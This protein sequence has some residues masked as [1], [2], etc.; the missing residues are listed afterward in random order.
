MSRKI[1]VVDDEPDLEALILQKFRK[2]IRS[3]ELK[4]YFA[5][6]GVKAL[7]KIKD[8]PDIEMVMT[9][10]N[11]P[12]MDGLTLLEELKR[13]SP[14]LMTVVVSAYGD[15]TN[16]R[17]AMNRGA[18]DFIT[19]PIDLEDLEITV[20][21]TLEQIK[22]VRN[23]IVTQD[24][25][26]FLEQEMKMA[27][28]LQQSILPTQFPST[29][30]YRL[31]AS[32]TP[33][34]DVGGDFYDFF[35]IDEDKIGVVIADVS[36]KGVTAALFMAVSRTLLRFI[37]QKQQLVDIGS[38]LAEVNKLLCLDNEETMFVTLF[39]GIM[40]LKTGCFTYSNAG[41]NP[42]YLIKQNGDLQKLP[43]DY[44]IALGVMNDVVFN[45]HTIEINKSDTLL[46]YTDG[47]TE[48]R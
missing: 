36:G 35:F 28:K 29:E 5:S 44:G 34:K 4:F 45:T 20:S 15:L 19:K 11:M 27:G 17:S 3:K 25:L 26:V 30:R 2:K 14:Q 42:P 24:K 16:I 1:L 46:L 47:V 21:K 18:F 22:S 10:I 40:D 33:A 13:S 43:M 12:D 48:G 37:V 38:C 6:N 8:Q 23:A 39:Y 9:D 7:S 31:Y 41:H 32:M